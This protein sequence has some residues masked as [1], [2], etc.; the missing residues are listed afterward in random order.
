M[1]TSSRVPPVMADAGT[2]PTTKLIAQVSAAN[3]HVDFFGISPP[4]PAVTPG[5]AGPYPQRMP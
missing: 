1:W 3:N 2:A 5:M 4:W